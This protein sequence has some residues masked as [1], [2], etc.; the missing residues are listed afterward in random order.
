ME[1]KFMP[2]IRI[3]LRGENYRFG[4]KSEIHKKGYKDQQTFCNDAKIDPAI[5]SRVLNGWLVPDP[6]TQK[7]LMDTLNISESKLFRLLNN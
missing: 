1:I 4:L 7:R 5:L 3:K 2:K 6:N